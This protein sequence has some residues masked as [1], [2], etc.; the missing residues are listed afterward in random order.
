M[1][2][3]T[4][5]GGLGLAA[6]QHGPV[7]HGKKSPGLVLLSLVGEAARN[8]AAQGQHLVELDDA[9]ALFL[10]TGQPVDHLAA[11]TRGIN[12][13][14]NGIKHI[15]PKA[16]GGA[17]QAGS[18]FTE[19]IIRSAMP[20]L[21]GPGTNQGHLGLTIQNHQLP[22]HLVGQPEII[23]I[24]RGDHG[25][26]GSTNSNRGRS[27]RAMVGLLKQA[28]W[29]AGA[30]GCKILNNGGCCI[31]AAI[32]NNND[33]LGEAAL[34]KNRIQTILDCALCV[35]C[36]NHSRVSEHQVNS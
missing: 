32:V 1:V 26:G 2:R 8:D 19:A 13:L 30:A 4:L 31:V 14:A 23:G 21:A 3:R 33:L 15:S 24:E 9:M 20:K 11:T 18:A 5:H 27:T 28:H 7:G 6:S 29:G 36:R 10:Q 25:R 34:A 12:D 17:Q 35:E 16:D 22:I